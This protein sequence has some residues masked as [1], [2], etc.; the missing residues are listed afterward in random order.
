MPLGIV[1]SGAVL[2]YLDLTQHTQLSHVTT[3]SRIEEDN[4]VRLDKFTIRNLELLQT[5]HEDGKT[6][7]EVLDKTTSPMGARMLRRW[8]VFPLKDVAA[9]RKRQQVV[10]HF[11]HC[12][13]QKEELSLLIGKTGD[14]ER[15]ISKA[16]VGRIAPR[17][18]VS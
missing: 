13:E 10:T 18:V 8:I 4:A 16:S 17:E 5:M 11:L 2:S 15:L 9:I 3:L 6:L 14:L 12:P 7:I 1:A